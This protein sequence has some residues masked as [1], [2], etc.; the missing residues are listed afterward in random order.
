MAWYPE[1]GSNRQW[2]ILRGLGISA[3]LG[4]KPRGEKK[5]GDVFPLSCYR[6]VFLLYDYLLIGKAG[7]FCF[8]EGPIRKMNLRC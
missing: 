5:E 3:S 1:T 2:R 6:L 4:N 7:S 8:I